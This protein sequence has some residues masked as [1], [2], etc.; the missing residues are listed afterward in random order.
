MNKNPYGCIITKNPIGAPVYDVIFKGEAEPTNWKQYLCPRE[1]Q[2]N[3][4]FCVTFS[5]LNCQEAVANKEGIQLNLSDRYLGV[6]SKTSKQG[7]D[8]HNVAETFRTVGVV[9]ENDC[10][11]R[12][13]WLSD[14]KHWDNAFDLWDIDPNARRYYGG[15]HSFIY[16]K[17]L[18][19]RAL[20]YSPIQLAVAVGANW[21][22]ENPIKNP[23]KIL[24][25]HAITAYWI[26]DTG[27]YFQDSCGKEFKTLSPDYRI[28]GA[29]SFRLL[30]NNWREIMYRLVQV[31]GNDKIYLLQGS[32][33]IHLFSGATREILGF[34]DQEPE[35]ITQEELDKYVYE[36]IVAGK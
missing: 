35:K 6:I 7:N 10:P 27:Y 12:D 19:S 16:D 5:C 20:H 28:E 21:E 1:R 14:I 25:H 36:T 17:N 18:V 3:W 34:K 30:P 4:P 9:K 24:A 23:D 15:D 31:E 13:D 11:W 22:T 29:K 26:D 33:A 8:L 32:R 2:Y